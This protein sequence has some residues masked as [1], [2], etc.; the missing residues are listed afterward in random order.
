MDGRWIGNFRGRRVRLLFS[1]NRLNLDQTLV[2]KVISVSVEVTG[3]PQT[4]VRVVSTGSPVRNI[5]DLPTGY[6]TINGY[7]PNW[8]KHLH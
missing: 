2:G 7:I 6:L 1:L 8:V 3:D 4:Y 5:N